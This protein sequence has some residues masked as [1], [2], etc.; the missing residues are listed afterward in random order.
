MLAMTGLQFIILQRGKSQISSFPAIAFLFFALGLIGLMAFRNARRKPFT[1]FISAIILLPLTFP[2][3]LNKLSWNGIDFKT[4]PVV[5]W[6]KTNRP[7]ARVVSVNFGGLF[8]IPPNLGQAYGIRCAEIAAAIF[9]NHY[10]SISPQLKTLPTVVLFDSSSLATVNQMGVTI[11]LLSNDVF[12]S[13][14]NLLFKGSSYSAYAIPGAHGRLYFAERACHYKPGLP[15]PRQILSLSQE[16]DAVAIVEDMGNSTP[17]VIPEIL[18]GKGMAAF[19]RDD[20][21]DILVRTECPLEGLLVLRD[22]WYPGWVAFVDGKKVPILRVNGCYRGAIVPAG[23]HRIRFVYRPI[24][25]YASGAVS[26]L[27]VVLVIFVSLWKSSRRR[28]APTVA[29]RS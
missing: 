23:E 24:L 7:E 22:S 29:S 26:L 15:F 14:V 9:L 5:E 12:S 18:S 11:V 4:N 17:A 28:I 20:P 3:S 8:A 1:L 27:T 6:L 25:V 21:D 10:R 2:L 16:T 13:R 19:E